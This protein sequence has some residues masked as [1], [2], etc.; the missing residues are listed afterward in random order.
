MTAWKLGLC[1]GPTAATLAHG[2]LCVELVDARVA[3]LVGRGRR[4]VE[5]AARVEYLGLPPKSQ[6]VQKEDT[7]SR[8]SQC[9]LRPGFQTPFGRKASGGPKMAMR[10]SPV[11]DGAVVAVRH[12]QGVARQRP[13]LEL[14]A[15]WGRDTWRR[16]GNNRSILLKTRPRHTAHTVSRSNHTHCEPQPTTAHL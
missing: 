11:E 13:R 9:T 3:S 1:G 4:G 6:S 5:A 10:H 2:A 15:G 8:T 14:C 16:E 7:P 12:H